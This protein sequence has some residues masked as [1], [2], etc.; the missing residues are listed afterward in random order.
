M[1]LPPCDL[2]GCAA[3][4]TFHVR[5]RARSSIT[6]LCWPCLTGLASGADYAVEVAATIVNVLPPAA[7]SSKPRLGGVQTAFAR[8]TG[9]RLDGTSKEPRQF[10]DLDDVIRTI[11]GGHREQS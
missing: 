11:L 5:V 8:V 10:D 7:G 1:S 9:N 4:Q 3:V 6:R 2:C